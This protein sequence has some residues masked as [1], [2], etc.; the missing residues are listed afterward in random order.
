MQPVTAQL[1]APPRSLARRHAGTRWLLFLQAGGQRGADEAVCAGGGA[2]GAAAGVAAP[3]RPLGAPSCAHPPPQEGRRR[4]R[5]RR[6]QAKACGRVCRRRGHLVRRAR[7]AAAPGNAAGVATQC[8]WGGGPA[9]AGGAA[10]RAGSR[11]P[12]RICQPFPGRRTAIP[13]EEARR[14]GRRGGGP[15]ARGVMCAGSCAEPTAHLCPSLRPLRAPPLSPPSLY[16]A[17]LR[18]ADHGNSPNTVRPLLP[19][20][21]VPPVASPMCLPN[22]PLTHAYLPP[23]DTPHVP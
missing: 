3:G 4:R 20:L 21:L 22:A 10:A 7:G 15:A 6:P 9:Q 11:G 17:C 18:F 8:P 23:R 5:C 14:C 13:Q 1:L 16:P 2:A 19:T 12:H